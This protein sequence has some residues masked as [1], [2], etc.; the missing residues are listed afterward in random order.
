MTDIYK[1]PKQSDYTNRETG[2]FEPDRY[3]KD[4]SIWK[5][6]S[7]TFSWNSRVKLQELID[8]RDW[9]KAIKYAEPILFS[10]TDCDHFQSVIQKIIFNN[11]GF[12]S[13]FGIRYGKPLISSV[14][15]SSGKNSQYVESY[16]SSVSQEVKATITKQYGKQIVLNGLISIS[17]FVILH[18]V[19]LEYQVDKLWLWGFVV[20]AWVAFYFTYFYWIPKLKN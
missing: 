18:T 16:N 6:N 3:Y 5:E 12:G 7:K 8:N 20:I 14:L 9:D 11:G 19:I 15:G 13:Q 17:L 4:L 10:K 2:E 1:E